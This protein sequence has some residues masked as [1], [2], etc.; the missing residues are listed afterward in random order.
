VQAAPVKERE[1]TIHVFDSAAESQGSN[2]NWVQKEL[3]RNFSHGRTDIDNFSRVDSF[4]N[5][6]VTGTRVKADMQSRR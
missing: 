4:G 3:C 2:H 5:R 6:I 1:E